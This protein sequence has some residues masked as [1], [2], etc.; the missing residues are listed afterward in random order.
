MLP[1][2]L[3][4]AKSTWR[5]I[6]SLNSVQGSNFF[7][8]TA[9]ISMQPDS[10]AFL[11]LLIGLLFAIPI[12]T[13]P[14]A[15]IPKLRLEL[16]PARVPRMLHWFARADQTRSPRLWRALPVLEL[17]QLARSLDLWLAVLLSLTAAFY[18]TVDP[19]SAP[20]MAL[21]V[22]LALSSHANNLFAA[23]LLSGRTRWKLSPIRGLS[24]LLRKGLPLIAI[25]VLLTLPL[26]PAA[27]LTAI[28]GALAIG[29]H[30]SVLA[31]QDSS[32]WRFTLSGVFPQGV[33]QAACIFG[34]GSA[35]AR[36]NPYTLPAAAALYTVSL[37]IY[38]WLFDN[39]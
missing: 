33:I 37:L 18:K 24:L 5:S 34:L 10:A 15:Q 9:F 31:P 25:S 19:N 2:F 22:V 27:G 35:T 11:W 14:L 29:H 8:F 23:D 39:D 36:G 20:I 6:R 30:N 17:R 38:A 3:A 26:Q 1:I 4:L 12:L 16:W 7:W 13:A 32:P 28:L 21:L